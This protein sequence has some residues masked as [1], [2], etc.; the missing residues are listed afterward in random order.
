LSLFF[1]RLGA[2]KNSMLTTPLNLSELRLFSY[3]NQDV[4]WWPAF[5][6]QFWTGQIEIIRTAEKSGIMKPEE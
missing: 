3:L 2:R 6:S 4:P 1:F 5:Y